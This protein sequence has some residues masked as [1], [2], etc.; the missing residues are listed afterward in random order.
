MIK[1]QVT[2]AIWGTSEISAASIE[3]AAEKALN[4]SLHAEWT[5]EGNTL[6]LWTVGM[7]GQE[8]ATY[9]IEPISRTEESPMNLSHQDNHPQVWTTE[10]I[11][12]IQTVENEFFVSIENGLGYDQIPMSQYIRENCP[13]LDAESTWN[14]LVD[15]KRE[16]LAAAEQHAPQPIPHEIA[17]SNCGGH[18]SGCEDWCGEYTPYSQVPDA[19][20][21]ACLANLWN[22][23]FE[24]EPGDPGF[25]TPDD[26]FPTEETTMFHAESRTIHFDDDTQ[27]T[28]WNVTVRDTSGL[29]RSDLESYLDELVDGTTFSAGSIGGHITLPNGE[30]CAPNVQDPVSGPIFVWSNRDHMDATFTLHYADNQRQGDQIFVHTTGLDNALRC[31][32]FSFLVGM[33]SACQDELELEDILETLDDG[34]NNDTLYEAWREWRARIQ[35]A[36]R[37]NSDGETAPVMF[38]PAND[39]EMC[40]GNVQECGTWCLAWQ[41]AAR[42]EADHDGRQQA[43][44]DFYESED[45]ENTDG[46]TCSEC[47]RTHVICPTHNTRIALCGCDHTNEESFVDARVRAESELLMDNPISASQAAD[48]GIGILTRGNTAA[49]PQTNPQPCEDLD[50]LL[51]E[52]GG[53]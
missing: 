4:L 51:A 50:Q 18:E 6:R 29:T 45:C 17:C 21:Q 53:A 25:M 33:H 22:E 7:A 41:D 5:L 48:D 43:L 28:Q 20:E 46:C 35:Q 31:D 24:L 12:F 16:M 44:R 47:V 19:A 2:P 52:M 13:G 23:I 11:H 27:I 14:E 34:W 9:T 39:C 26:T 40:N 3:D 15:W 8:S 49:I 1:F 30:E 42:D 37:T 36:S 38:E 32:A 10:G